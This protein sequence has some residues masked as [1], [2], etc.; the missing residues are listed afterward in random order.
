MMTC[1]ELAELLMAF[2]DG[3]LS[4]ESCDL[5]CQHIRLCRPCHHFMESYQITVRICRELP[6]APL[7]EHLLAKVRA[8]LKEMGERPCGE[9]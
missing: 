2:C 6:A 8:A 4:K 7:P 9:A 5:I 1:K 3:E